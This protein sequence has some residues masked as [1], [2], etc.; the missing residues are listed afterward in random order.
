MSNLLGQRRNSRKSQQMSEL[1]LSIEKQQMERWKKL[2][3]RLE[4]V[5]VRQSSSDS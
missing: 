1:R 3:E 2:Q 5:Q 4:A